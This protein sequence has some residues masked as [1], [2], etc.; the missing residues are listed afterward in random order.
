MK[1]FVFVSCILSFLLVIHPVFADQTASST[2]PITVRIDFGPAD[3]P[4]IEKQILIQDQSTPKEAIKSF[5]SIQEGFVCCH[6]NEIKG[7]DGVSADPIKN[8]WW[9]LKINGDSRNVSPEK[10]K[11]KAGDVME[12][13]YFEDVQ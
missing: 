10:S 8:R 7:I 1:R 4:S 11:L 12:W 2:V 9:R 5:I 3:R 13:V 6:D